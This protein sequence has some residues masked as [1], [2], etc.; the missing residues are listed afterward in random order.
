MSTRG[1]RGIIGRSRARASRL[2][3]LL[4]DLGSGRLLE[5]AIYS[6]PIMEERALDA[7]EVVVSI[8]FRGRH[9]W[10]LSFAAQAVQAGQASGRLAAVEGGGQDGG[11]PDGVERQFAD[12]PSG[13]A[14]P[15]PGATP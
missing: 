14:P 3:S 10:S 15:C 6:G 4:G 11:F 1:D 12:V 13:D 2:S 9:G 7:E 5:S 8:D